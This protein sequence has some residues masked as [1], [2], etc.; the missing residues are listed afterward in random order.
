MTSQSA[1]AENESDKDISLVRYANLGLTKAERS[2]IA[3]KAAETRR[4]NILKRKRGGKGKARI[5]PPSGVPRAKKK[6]KKPS[7]SRS[8]AARKA[9]ATR[10]KNEQVVGFYKKDKKTRPITKPKAETRRK[11]VV[12]KPREF[13]GVSPRKPQKFGLKTGNKMQRRGYNYF[14]RNPYKLS[15]QDVQFY[16]KR[17]HAFVENMRRYGIRTKKQAKDWLTGYTVAMKEHKMES[18]YAKPKLTK[19]EKLKSTMGLKKPKKPRKWAQKAQIK[20]GALTQLGYDPYKSDGSRHKALKLSI[21]DVGLPKTRSRIQFLANVTPD[22]KKLDKIY[23]SDLKWLDKKYREQF[24]GLKV[25]R[26]KKEK[27]KKKEPKKE[28][29]LKQGGASVYRLPAKRTWRRQSKSTPGK[30]YTQR[31]NVDDTLRCNCPGWIFSEYPKSCTHTREIA[32]K[33]GVGLA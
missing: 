1:E 17:P 22:D 14:K 20:K 7:S 18:A 29:R 25:Q 9:W 33:H 31:L 26:K 10:R 8:N 12:T 23:K 4:K 30:W 5:H 15:L 19:A 2:A 28:L 24:P 11:K 16:L 21:D 3:R 27:P 13:K 32:E 6:K